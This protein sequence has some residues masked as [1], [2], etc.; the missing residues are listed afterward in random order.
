MDLVFQEEQK[1]EPTPPEPL[2]VSESEA[3]PLVPE[4]ARFVTDDSMFDEDKDGRLT[5]HFSVQEVAKIFFGNGP[6][7]LRWRMR[8]DDK[9]VKGP[10]GKFL[11]NEDGT[12]VMKPDK[13]P[14]GYFVLDGEVMDFKRT[15]ADA[16]YFTLADIE[17]MAH[18]LAQGDNLD[19]EQLIN[20][21]VLVKTIAK[22]YGLLDKPKEPNV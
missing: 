9:K 7:W 21:I 8:P 22:V 16:R 14:E 20:V 19:G 17:R 2:V 18:A 11:R 15:P 6:D 12:F 13:Y 5:P 1:P 3:E 4:G 10:D